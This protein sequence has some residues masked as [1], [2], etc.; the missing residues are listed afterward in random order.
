MC[1]ISFSRRNPIWKKKFAI[2]VYQIGIQKFSV[3]SDHKG[4]TETDTRYF[5]IQIGNNFK[6]GHAKAQNISRRLPVAVARVRS[7]FRSCGV[8]G[9]RSGTRT[10]FL[11]VFRFPLPILIAPNA[12]YSSTIRGWYNRPT[13][14]RRTKWTQSHP[15]ARNF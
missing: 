1:S 13:S 10:D 9:G 14:G 12:P 8:C 15:T 11:R 4:R 5:Y 2:I 7:Q 6:K 3:Y